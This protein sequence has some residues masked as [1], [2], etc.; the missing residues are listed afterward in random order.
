MANPDHLALFE[1]YREGLITVGK[2]RELLRMKTR[3]EVDAFLQAKG[4]NLSDS[5]VDLEADLQS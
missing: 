4:V 5:E 1:A 3:L 2:V